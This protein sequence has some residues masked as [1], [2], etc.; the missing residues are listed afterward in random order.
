MAF[1]LFFS[2][3]DLHFLPLLRDLNDLVSLLHDWRQ[4]LVTNPDINPLLHQFF[5]SHSFFPCCPFP[6]RRPTHLCALPLPCQRGRL[7][8]SAHESGLGE[9]CHTA[10]LCPAG[11]QDPAALAPARCAHRSGRGRGGCEYTPTCKPYIFRSVTG[12]IVF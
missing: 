7:R 9:L 12:K 3:W 5:Y 10:A 6:A 11:E 1:N 4:S 8:H 2:F